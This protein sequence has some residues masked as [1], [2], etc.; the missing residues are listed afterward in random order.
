MRANCRRKAGEHGC[1]DTAAISAIAANAW[2]VT[3]S[4]RSTAFSA[5]PCRSLCSLRAASRL[6][7]YRLVRTGARVAT[8]ATTATETDISERR[9]MELAPVSPGYVPAATRTLQWVAARTAL[10]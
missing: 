1:W 3:S 9:R 2:R 4:E 7:T 6:A 10:V 5:Y 8:Q